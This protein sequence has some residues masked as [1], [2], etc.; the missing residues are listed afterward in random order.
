MD[1]AN[2]QKHDKRIFFAIFDDFRNG[3]S[4]LCVLQHGRII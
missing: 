3:Q 4:D 2:H 1:K